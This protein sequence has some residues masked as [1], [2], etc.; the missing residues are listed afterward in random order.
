[1]NNKTLVLVLICVA[2]LL[3][4][5]SVY[6]VDLQGTYF[7]SL[8]TQAGTSIDITVESNTVEYGDHYSYEVNLN[9]GQQIDVKLEVPSGADFDLFFCTS[10]M[11]LWWYNTSD[12]E[13]QDEN[14]LITVPESGDYLF[15]AGGYSGNGDY[16]LRWTSTNAGVDLT[17]ILGVVA[18]GIIIAVVVLVLL[19]RLRK[20]APLDNSRAIPPPPP[21]T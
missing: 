6:A 17:F 4:S 13:G 1:M 15:V 21:P 18:V 19:M 11:S 10:N 9:K 14:Q 20:R 8:D 7:G 3:P 5:S 12:V 16:T 2:L